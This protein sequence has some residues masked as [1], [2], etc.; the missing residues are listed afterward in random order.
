MDT[1]FTPY[2]EEYLIETPRHEPR[3]APEDFNKTNTSFQYKP[4]VY[5]G[6][7]RTATEETKIN[8]LL[9]KSEKNTVQ[10]F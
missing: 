10:M 3:G 1:W 6:I 8:K 2:L 9:K 5:E 4:E 7:A